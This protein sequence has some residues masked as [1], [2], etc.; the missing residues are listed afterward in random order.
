MRPGTDIDVRLALSAYA[1]GLFPMDD[2]A[3][4]DRP[5]PF[6]V[7]DPRAVLEIDSDSLAA[8]R[9]RVRRSLAADPGWRPVV[10]SAFEET[11]ERCAADRGDGNVAWISPRLADLYRRIHAVGFAHS[12]EL[13]DGD[14]LAAGVLAVRI[15]RAAM[16][17]SMFHAVAHA[18]NVCLVRTLERLADEGVELCDIQL[19]TPH[20]TRLGAREI[21]REEYEKRLDAALSG[22]EPGV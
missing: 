5:L 18:G 21:T 13:W 9:R 8:T 7:A 14:R 16:L 4:Q 3:E 12:Y 20:T 22:V 2:P 17:E 15:G 1:Q 10:D 6:W 11:L 19:T